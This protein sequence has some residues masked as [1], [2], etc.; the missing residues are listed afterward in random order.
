MEMG[1]CGRGGGTANEEL[2]R[3]VAGDG[4]GGGSGQTNHYT[5]QP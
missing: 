1:P 5:W 4:G 3:L 2:V